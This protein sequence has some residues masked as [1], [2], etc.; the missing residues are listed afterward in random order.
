[1]Q[2]SLCVATGSATCL[3]GEEVYSGPIGIS[4]S[5]VGLEGPGWSSFVGI[6]IVVQIFPSLLNI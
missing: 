2:D 4:S 5:L 6:S 3:L 1:M